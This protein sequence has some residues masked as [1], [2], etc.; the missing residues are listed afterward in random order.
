MQ[1]HQQIQNLLQ[2]PD[3]GVIICLIIVAR[4]LLLC[5]INTIDVTLHLEEKTFHNKPHHSEKT[6]I[7]QSFDLV[8]RYVFICKKQRTLIGDT[9]LQSRLVKKMIVIINTIVRL[10]HLIVTVEVSAPN[11]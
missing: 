7:L 4:R 1:L 11:T 9:L 3:M 10:N 5:I 6:P 2:I 8:L